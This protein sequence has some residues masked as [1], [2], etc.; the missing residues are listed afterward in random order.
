MG[1]KKP[2]FAWF[3]DNYPQNIN[4]KQMGGPKYIN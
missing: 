1:L 2:F 3:R 4:G